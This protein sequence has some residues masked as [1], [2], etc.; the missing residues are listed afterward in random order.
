MLIATLWHLQIDL[1]EHLRSRINQ[2]I[3]TDCRTF[4]PSRPLSTAYKPFCTQLTKAFMA[5]TFCNQ[6]QLIDCFCPVY[7]LTLSHVSPGEVL[8]LVGH[9]QCIL[10]GRTYS[11]T[12]TPPLLPS[13]SLSPSAAPPPPLPPFSSRS[14]P[15]PLLPLPTDV[16]VGESFEFACGGGGR[17]GYWNFNGNPIGQ[18]EPTSFYSG[19]VTE[20][21]DGILTAPT[22]EELCPM[23]V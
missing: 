18:S 2:S 19:T 6:F 4:W 10:Y 7:L 23:E 9:M 16:F 17:T 14:P 11:T 8:G 13:P 15:F 22:L 20:S 12:P 21:L 3:A 5:E 1:V